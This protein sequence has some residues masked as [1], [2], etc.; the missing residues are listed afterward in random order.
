MKQI[1]NVLQQSKEKRET[2]DLNLPSNVN[3]PSTFLLMSGEIKSMS[4]GKARESQARDRSPATELW[5]LPSLFLSNFADVAC[6]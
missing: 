5:M 4:Q 2:C 3:C 6:N 1:K